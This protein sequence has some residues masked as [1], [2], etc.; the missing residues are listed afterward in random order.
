MKKSGGGDGERGKPRWA[1]IP[2]SVHTIFYP[3]VTFIG[4]YF[5]PTYIIIYY[6]LYILRERI[7]YR[8]FTILLCFILIHFYF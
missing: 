6:I 5:L 1:Y 8:I 7:T 2:N 3:I 4:Y